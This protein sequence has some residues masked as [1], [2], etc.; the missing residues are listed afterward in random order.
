M[1]RHV[2]WYYL[3]VLLV[4]RILKCWTFGHLFLEEGNR[5]S[6]L[7]HDLPRRSPCRPRRH[8]VITELGPTATL[9]VLVGLAGS[10]A[11]F[12]PPARAGRAMSAQMVTSDKSYDNFRAMFAARKAANNLTASQAGA[13]STACSAQEATTQH[14]AVSDKSSESF[15]AMFAARQTSGDQWRGGDTDNAPRMMADGHAA[16]PAAH[17]PDSS[18]RFDTRTHQWRDAMGFTTASPRSNAIDPPCSQQPQS[19][20][21]IG[22]ATLPAAAQGSQD[23]V[24]GAT[25][26]AVRPKKRVRKL[27]RPTLGASPLLG[28]GAGDVSDEISE[29]RERAQASTALQDAL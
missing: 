26:V 17:D 25:M 10:V 28:S 4:I 8:N 9:A 27:T 15:R 19:M 16:A 18:V 24:M 20:D 13:T 21:A 3:K 12:A 29:A 6:N 14:A 11:S 23:L 22:T 1:G 5:R 7:P 2:L